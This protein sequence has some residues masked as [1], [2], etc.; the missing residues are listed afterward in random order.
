MVIGGVQMSMKSFLLSNK[1]RTG[2]II[3]IILILS[4]IIPLI[5]FTFFADP[6]HPYT[7]SQTTLVTEDYT[8][9]KALIYTP[10]NMTGNHPGVVIGHGFCGNARHMQALA[11]EFVKREFVV[12]NI[13]FRGHGN[14]GGYLP[15]FTDPLMTNTIELDILA[16]IQY[17]RD[18]GNIDKIGLLGHSMGAMTVLKTA[19]DLTNDI[20]ATVVLGMVTGFEAGLRGFI[21][22][23]I[24]GT[25]EPNLTRIA[26]LLICNGR[27]EQMFTPTLSLNFLKEY[28]NLTSVELETTYGYFEYRNA[29]KVVIGSG[30]HLFEPLDNHIINE[31]VVWFELAFY[32]SIRWDVTLTAPF[33]QPSFAIALIGIIAM[34]FVTLLYLHNFLWKD[35]PINLRKNTLKDTS[36]FKLIVFYVLGTVV[37]VGLLLPFAILFAAALPIS[38]GQLLYAILVGNAIGA[39]LMYY[40]IIRKIEKLGFRAIP[41]KIRAMCSGDYKRSILYGIIAAALLAVAI[42]CVANWS[43]VITF[44][45]IREYGGIIGMAI[46]FFPWLLIKEFYFR[47]TQGQLKTS[48]RFKEYFT[49]VGIGF[50]MD[51]LL[52]IPAM[53]FFWRNGPLL[54]FLAL[55]LTVVLIFTFIQQILVT[56][57]YMYSGRNILGSTIFLCIFYAWMIINFYPFGLPFF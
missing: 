38:M 4:G 30:E 19:D 31:S 3:S 5:I 12:V 54:G 1:K 7:I 57:V 32:G 21:G 45:T 14:S 34:C 15:S 33:L 29:S 10:K 41:S 26:N 53:L 46:L 56:W 49:M 43:I 18:L 11:I 9:I 50:V 36:I 35:Q 44:P 8:N 25:S 55:A 2:L 28:T 48:N 20:N 16:G 39:L 51:S 6:A 24:S 40:F 17:L 37:G 22:G 27:L 52:L 42:A 23:N 13:N 47:T